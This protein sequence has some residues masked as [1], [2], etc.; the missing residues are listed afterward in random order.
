MAE[1]NT[2]KSQKGSLHGKMETILLSPYTDMDSNFPSIVKVLK[3]Q[4]D[5]ANSLHFLYLK[6]NVK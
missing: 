3:E 5:L 6:R 2:A 4:I 1:K